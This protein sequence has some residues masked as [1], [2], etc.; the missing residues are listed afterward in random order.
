MLNRRKEI[1]ELRD[2]VETLEQQQQALEKRCTE[3]YRGLKLYVRESVDRYF[4][5]N[6]RVV[7]LK[8]DKN[9][10]IAQIEKRAMDNLFRKDDD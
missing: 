9:E 10:M 2:L 7:M 5:E 1:E 4:E 8:R 6:C 3:F